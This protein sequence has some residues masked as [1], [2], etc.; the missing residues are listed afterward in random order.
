MPSWST[1]PPIGPDT[2]TISDVTAEVDDTGVPIGM[3]VGSGPDA[4]PAGA[5]GEASPMGPG[6]HATHPD[7]VLTPAPTTRRRKVLNRWIRGTWCA[8]A[9]VLAMSAGIWDTAAPPS[10]PILWNL[11]ITGAHRGLAV[12][13]A[14][15]VLWTV[16]LL[17]ILIRLGEPVEETPLLLRRILQR[18]IRALATL[19]T[20]AALPLIGLMILVSSLSFPLATH[21]VLPDGPTGCRLYAVVDDAYDGTVTHF[22]LLA[23]GRVRAEETSTAWSTGNDDPADP[24]VALQWSLAWEGGTATLTP[25]SSLRGTPA[26]TAACPSS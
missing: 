22:Y 11:V 3:D 20:L 19:A 4:H 24:L 14:A 5:S 17:L 23:P 26:S 21:H 16:S 2:P 1:V 12:A 6:E 10:V 7:P 18:A 9:V 25:P 15:L 8:G 13:T